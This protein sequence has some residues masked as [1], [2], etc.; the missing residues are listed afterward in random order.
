MRTS[1]S[2]MF[3]MNSRGLV[4]RRKGRRVKEDRKS[5]GNLKDNRKEKTMQNKGRQIRRQDDQKGQMEIEMSCLRHHIVAL[6]YDSKTYDST[7]NQITKGKR[8]R[9]K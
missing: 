6:I 9:K 1:C 3:M 5:E 8:G 2:S 7:V 4:R